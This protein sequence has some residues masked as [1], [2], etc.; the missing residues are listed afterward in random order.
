MTDRAFPVQLEGSWEGGEI[1]STLVVTLLLF[2]AHAYCHACT[3]LQL[4]LT[5][6]LTMLAT[7]DVAPTLTWFKYANLKQLYFVLAI[8]SYLCEKQL[9]YS[10]C[11]I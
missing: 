11:N 9:L 7:L 2:P 6:A 3:N 1:N 4:M 8:R 5:N 10:T